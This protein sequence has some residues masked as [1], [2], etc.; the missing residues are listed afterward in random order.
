M[1]APTA[2]DWEMEL[3]RAQNA[4]LQS[5]NPVYVVEA[6]VM[7]CGSG[8]PVPEWVLGYLFDGMLQYIREQGKVSLGQCLR[9]QPGKGQDPPYKVKLLRERNLWLT[10]QICCLHRLGYS[11][12]DAARLLAKTVERTDWNQSQWDVRD[13]TAEN[14]SRNYLNDWCKWKQRPGAGVVTYIIDSQLAEGESAYLAKFP[15]DLLKHFKPRQ[16]NAGR[17]ANG[18]KIS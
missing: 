1:P 18:R 17:G 9:L 13:L 6:F 2:D 12:L 3:R 15:P 7:A 14:I 11:T 10:V 5:G 16:R 4:F 8:S